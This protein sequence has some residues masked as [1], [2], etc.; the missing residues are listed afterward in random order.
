MAVYLGD[1][2]K[3]RHIPFEE[4]GNHHYAIKYLLVVLIQSAID[5]VSHIL[6]DRGVL[7]PDSYRAVFSEAADQG[8]LDRTLAGSLERAVGM[9]NMIVHEY[10][11]IDERMVWESIPVALEDIGAFLQAME[12]VTEP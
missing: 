12:K 1:L 5:L 8:L 7:R 6:A 11:R 2:Q 4:Y 9:R 10:D 3:Y